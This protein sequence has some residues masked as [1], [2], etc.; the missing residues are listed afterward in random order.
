MA[1]HMGSH[2]ITAAEET[3]GVVNIDTGGRIKSA[4]IQIG[5]AAA[6]IWPF[7]WKVSFAGSTLT[8]SNGNSDRFHAGLVL[9]WIVA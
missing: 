6:S 5:E 3:A 2:I 1:I 8:V 7:A 4:I 9:T